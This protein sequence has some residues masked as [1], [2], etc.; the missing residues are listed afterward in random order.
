VSEPLVSVIIPVYQGERIVLGAVRSALRQ[1]HANLEVLVVDDGSTDATQDVL[2]R[3]DDPRVYVM[4]QANAGTAAARNLALARA[5]GSYI[6][7]LDSDDRWFP[8]KIATELR[9]LQNAPAPI[10]IAYSSYYPVD[11]RGRLVHLPANR[12]HSGNALEVLLDGEDFLM[13]SVCLFDRR[14]FDTI[15]HFSVGRYHEDHEFILRASRLYPIFP[16]SRRLV[17]YRQST[18][19]KCRR[20]LRDF[21][22]ARAEELSIAGDFAPVLTAEQNLR[23]HQNVR[24]SLYCRFL[25]YGFNQNAKRML[26]EVELDRL[27]ANGKGRLAWIFSWSGINLL[28][29]ARQAVQTSYRLFAQRSW[30]RLLARSGVDLLYG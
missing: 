30:H 16:T 19:G 26:D 2:A 14:I 22:R 18:S 6:A 20:I 9:T 17:V 7:F 12:S 4:R 24:R 25:M 1:T 11:D 27:P 28:A 21:E 13:P 10:A 29:A 23:L 8:D 3:L 15:G 5:R